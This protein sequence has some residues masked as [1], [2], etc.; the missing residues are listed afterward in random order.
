MLC[1]GWKSWGVEVK[2]QFFNA[3]SWFLCLRTDF[4]LAQLKS[5][6]IMP[7]FSSLCHFVWTNLAKNGAL[8]AFYCASNKSLLC[9]LQYRTCWKPTVVS[10]LQQGSE[11]HKLSIFSNI[12]G[13]GLIRHDWSL[14]HLQ[15]EP[16]HRL[17]FSFFFLPTKQHARMKK[18]LWKSCAS[19]RAAYVVLGEERSSVFNP[20]LWHTDSFQA[21]RHTYWALK[22]LLFRN[23]NPATL[24]LCA[25]ISVW[26]LTERLAGHSSSA[27]AFWSL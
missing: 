7:F 4:L 17:K 12:S 16:F 10:Q 19:G 18:G 13:S 1:V 22:S 11:V 8:Q 24:R 5:Y 6:P 20:R 2:G 3:D 27:V 23:M 15:E 9:R 14:N 21:R 26:L 25:F